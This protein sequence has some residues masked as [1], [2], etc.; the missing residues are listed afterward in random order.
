MRREIVVAQSAL[1]RLA[2]S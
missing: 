1:P 2:S